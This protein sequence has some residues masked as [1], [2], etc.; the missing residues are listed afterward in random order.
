MLIPLQDRFRRRITYLRLSLTD[1]CNFRCL[2]CMPNHSAYVPDLLHND[3]LFII[4]QAFTQLGVNKIRL[5]GGEPLLRTNIVSLAKR[6]STLDGLN[7]LTLTTNGWLLQSLAHPL[8]V[9]GI[10][11]VNISLDTLQPQRFHR[12]T[13]QRNMKR[14]LDGIEAACAAGFE[15]VKI[16]VVM[17]KGHNDDEIVPL[18]EFA[19]QRGMD[20]S[21]IEEMPIGRDVH[22]RNDQIHCDEIY[23]RIS[24]HYSLLPSSENSG[25]PAQYHYISNNKHTRIG[26]IAPYSANFCASCNRVRLTPNGDL[27]LCL[28]NEDAVNLRTIVRTHPHDPIPYLTNAIRKAITHK[29]ERHHFDDLSAPQPLRWMN[30]IGG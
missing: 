18:I 8:R 13:G 6:L 11:R 23:R 28:G 25:G 29:P 9:A 7:E 2:Y 30:A 26:F 5:T 15:R 21:F 14:V 20:I 22:R 12:L 16:N 1:R 24:L 19:R 17:L 10:K 4:A 27:L 3:E